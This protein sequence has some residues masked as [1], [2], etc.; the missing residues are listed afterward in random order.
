MQ[1]NIFVLSRN[2]FLLEN[3]VN[4][5]LYM[6][7]LNQKKVKWVVR[8]MDKGERSVYRIAKTMKITP[9]WAREI[10]RTYPKTGEYPFPQEPGRKPRLISTEERNLILEVRKR[11]SDI[12]SSST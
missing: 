2:Y 10:H 9:Q 4:D 1:S 7:K 12:W 8:E 5:L 11:P 3:K 6:K